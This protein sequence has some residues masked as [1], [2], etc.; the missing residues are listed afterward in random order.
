MKLKTRLQ[1]MRLRLLSWYLDIYCMFERD[2]G[3]LSISEL[4]HK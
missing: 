1:V 2:D 4:W 3:S